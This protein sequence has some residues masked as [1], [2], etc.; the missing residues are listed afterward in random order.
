[1]RDRPTGVPHHGDV[2][3]ANAD[4]PTHE[5]QPTVAD[6][7]I[8]RQLNAA[9][10]AGLRHI[11]SKQASAGR[12]HGEVGWWSVPSRIQASHSGSMCLNDAGLRPRMGSGPIGLS[13]P[14]TCSPAT[15]RLLNQTRLP[16]ISTRA[17]SRARS[18]PRSDRWNFALWVPRPRLRT[19]RPRRRMTCPAR[20]AGRNAGGGGQGLLPR[21][22]RAAAARFDTHRCSCRRQ[23]QGALRRC[24]LGL[25]RPPQR[26][27]PRRRGGGHR[28]P[29]ERR[30]RGLHIVAAR[31]ALEQLCEIDL[32]LVVA[33]HPHREV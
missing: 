25:P 6:A 2:E 13:R 5:A 3:S 16:R 14:L 12:E 7:D 31:L 33:G 4:L 23:R 32:A 9:R 29:C 20:A 10:G 21:T 8:S 17:T 30:Q 19:Q 24:A 26:R 18:C 11:L 1:M 28:K 22:A 27:R 15:W